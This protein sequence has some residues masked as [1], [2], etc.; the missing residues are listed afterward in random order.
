MYR[1]L[2]A[3]LTIPWLRLCSRRQVVD[4]ELDIHAVLKAHFRLGLEKPVIPT[5]VFSWLWL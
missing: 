5:T 2:H 3:A 4:R 1:V